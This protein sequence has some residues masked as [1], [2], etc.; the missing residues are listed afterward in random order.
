MGL[1]D[2]IRQ[3]VGRGEAH[4]ALAARTVAIA[5]HAQ[6]PAVAAVET[7]RLLTEVAPTLKE[8]VLPDDLRRELVLQAAEAA[9]QAELFHW[10][11]CGGAG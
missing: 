9:W 3:A 10:P 5:Q 7:W 11:N 1:D 8:P 2:E 6:I 4:A